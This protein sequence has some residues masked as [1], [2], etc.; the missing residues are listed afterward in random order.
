M[1]CAT[2]A[3]PLSATRLDAGQEALGS[4]RPA[5]RLIDLLASSQVVCRLSG[6]LSQSP[7]M[8]AVRLVLSSRLRVST[9]PL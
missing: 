2:F 3:S 9:R 1:I 8:K 5:I 7:A 4:D 6:P